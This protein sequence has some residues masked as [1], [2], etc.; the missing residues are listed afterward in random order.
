MRTSGEARPEP[1]GVGTLHV[2]VALEISGYDESQR[3]LEGEHTNR[4]GIGRL[5]GRRQ[6]S[7]ERKLAIMWQIM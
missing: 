2:E 1:V 4:E 6:A 5:A 7:R 3:Q